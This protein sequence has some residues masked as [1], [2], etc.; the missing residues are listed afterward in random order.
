MPSFMMSSLGGTDKSV[1]SKYL[2]LPQGSKTQCMYI[3]IDGTGE[4]L[5]AKTKTVDEVP[6]SPKE[7]PIWNFDGSSTYQAEGSNSDVYLY[8]RALYEDPFRGGPNK[9]VLCDTYKYNK[10]PTDTNRR[11]TCADVMEKSKE[12]EPWFGI[13][14]EY[15]LLDID[16]HPL[17]W[18]KN[19]FP[20]PQGPYYCGVGADKVNGRDI[21]EAHYRA[22]LFAGINI[23]GT[24]AE[25]MPAQWEYQVGPCEGI[26][27]GDQLWMSRFLLHRVSEDFGVV[28]SLD[29]KPMEG[30]WNGAGAHTNF[31]T[32]DMR[33]A[34]GL[35]AIEEAIEKL[36][37]HHVRHIKAYDPKEGKDNERRLTGAHE[38]S[39]IHDFSAGVANRGCSIRIPRNVVEDGCGYLEDRRPSSNCDPYSVTE[40]IVRTTIL[41][42]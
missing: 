8:P 22:C 31:S 7:L 32:L 19:G 26:A 35:K 28:A 12:Q 30:D 37:H 18:P 14:Q 17:G 25:V 40:V 39:S 41:N 6:K 15:T 10:K 29:P 20:G 36:S 11:H 9:L 21:V 23:S 27:M 4:F 42:E 13:E 38:T 16:G 34:G 1:L 5:R 3:W 33:L 2:T 24:N